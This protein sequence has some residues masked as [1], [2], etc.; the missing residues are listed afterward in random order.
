MTAK[1]PGTS[2]QENFSIEMFCLEIQRW[3]WP[4]GMGTGRE[5]HSTTPGN[6]G[7]CNEKCHQGLTPT[8]HGNFGNENDF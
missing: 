8:I 7:N 2:G 4:L 6:I 5:S 1:L 3:T